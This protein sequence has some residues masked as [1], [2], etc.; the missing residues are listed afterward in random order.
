M[1]PWTLQSLRTPRTSWTLSTPWTLWTL[2]MLLLTCS[3]PTPARGQTAVADVDAAFTKFWEART[4]SDAAR[5]AD[6]VLA[7]GVGYEDALKRLRQGRSYTS[8]KPGVVMLTNK[9]EDRVEHYYAVT[10]PPA[11]DPAKRYQ[12]RFQLHGGVM[13]RSTNQPRNAGDIGTLAG[14]EQFYV[15][16]VR[17]DR[18]AMV[19]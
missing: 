10:V 12:V 11:Y 19:E 13:G 16:P 1:K 3:T 7:A 8:Q 5:A 14:A 15:I 18:R 9:T 4:P 17:L 2:W 6:A